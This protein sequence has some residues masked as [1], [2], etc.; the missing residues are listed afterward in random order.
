MA[1]PQR[2]RPQRTLRRPVRI[3]GVGYWS[4]RAVNLE[5]RPAP[6]G[7][8]VVFV[9]TDCRP[10]VRLPVTIERRVDACARTN[11]GTGGV[12][13]E[14]I[15]H[16]TSCL[17]GL[18]ID[19]CEIRIDAEELPGLDGSA[20]A[21]V[22]AIDDAGVEQ[23]G[24]PARPI[25]VR[26]P[27]RVEEGDAWVEALPPTHD[28]LSVDYTLE[29]GHPAIGHQ[30]FAI[31]VTPETY[32]MQL[33][34]ART[35]V[36]ADEAARLRAAGLGGHVTRADL[37]VFGEEGLEENQLRWPD[38]CARHKALDLVGDLTLAGRPVHAVVRGC[39]SGH[40]LN[41]RLVRHLL[42]HARIVEAFSRARRTA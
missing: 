12:R 17:A 30:R 14:M 15:E 5:C 20:Q 27:V 7:F 19:C 34:A 35:F 21:Y 36:T 40:R 41:A 11:L 4:G 13:V 18:G 22:E 6:A 1:H 2:P 29:H 10:A 9:R 24:A 42:A 32:R 3:S 33:A 23:L 16:V 25:V 39:R 26:T 28:G 38:E 8:G 31:D 37:L